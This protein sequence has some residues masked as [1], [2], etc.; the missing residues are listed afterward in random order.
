MDEVALP[1]VPALRLVKPPAA[2]LPKPLRAY[3]GAQA[4]Q[5]QLFLK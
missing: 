3:F 2:I 4:A 5:V 1:N